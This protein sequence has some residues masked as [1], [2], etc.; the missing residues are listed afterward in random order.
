[1]IIFGPISAKPQAAYVPA[2]WVVSRP[3]DAEPLAYPLGPFGRPLHL[4]RLFS[5]GFYHYCLQTIRMFTAFRFYRLLTI[6]LAKLWKSKEGS[7]VGVVNS[8]VQTIII[9]WNWSAHRTGLPCGGTRNFRLSLQG[10]QFLSI[11]FRSSGHM[12]TMRE[13]YQ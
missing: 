12:F 9:F 1:M 3:A 2:E 5:Y 6:L 13:R 7:N 8:M 10:F 4:Q 11:V